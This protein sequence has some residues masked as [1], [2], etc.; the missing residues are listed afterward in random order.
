MVRCFLV[1]EDGTVL[2]G[3]S[4]GHEGA[5]LGE[6]VFT[7]SMSGYQESITDPA[8]KDQI[9]VSAFPLVGSYGVSERF[10]CSDIVH[11]KGMVVREYCNEPSDMYGGRTLD[12]YLKAHKVPG[13]SGIDTRDVVMAVRSNGSMNAALVFDDK[14]IPGVK[15]RLKEKIASKDLVTLVSPKKIRKIDNK[16]KVTVGLIDCGA[17][18][19]LITDLSDIY[20]IVIFPHDTKAKDIL[21]SN[22]K[23]VVISNGPGDPS[24]PEIMRTAVNTV[25]ELRSKVPIAGI[26]FGAQVIAAAFGCK[27]VKLKFGHHGSSQ[28]VKHE[29]RAYITYQNHMFTI[30]PGTISGT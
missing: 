19:S 23:A 16:K 12:D 7:T 4:F 29:K 28:P 15:K 10:E 11:I 20:N 3:V 1:L 26:S 22:V 5:V 17:C 8:Y 30:D 9:L 2:E 13:I 25:K 6:L 14:E 21:D 18:R 24:H 27:I